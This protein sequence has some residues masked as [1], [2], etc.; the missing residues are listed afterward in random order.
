M[1]RLYDKIIE[2][3]AKDRTIVE[4]VIPQARN[5][6]VSLVYERGTVLSRKYNGKDILLQAELDQRT[7]QSLKEFI[8]KKRQRALWSSRL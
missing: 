1:E 7:A 2:H 8:K 4:L 3:F 5:D 6:L